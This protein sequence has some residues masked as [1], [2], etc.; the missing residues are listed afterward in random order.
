MPRVWPQEKKKNKEE[1]KKKWCNKGLSLL[2]T[3][4][5][6]SGKWDGEVKKERGQYSSVVGLDGSLEKYPGSLYYLIMGNKDKKME[7][8]MEYLK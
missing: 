3:I 7:R 5:P 2:P 8:L 4:L 6:G 1:D